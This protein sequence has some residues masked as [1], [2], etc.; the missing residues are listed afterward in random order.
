MLTSFSA[1]VWQHVPQLAYLQFPWRTLALLA[2]I[3]ALML[4]CALPVWIKARS[5][6]LSALAAFGI[7]AL[8]GLPAWHVFH[9]FCDPEDTAPARIAL[10]HSNAGTDPADYTPTAA[11]DDA[12]SHRNPAWWLTDSPDT[13]AP[14]EAP[15]SATRTV[16]ANLDITAAHAGF[17]V[18]NLR[19][20][21]AWRVTLAHDNATPQIVTARAHRSDGLLTIPVPSGRSTINIRYAQTADQTAGDIITLIALALAAA[22]VARN[23][24]L[25]AMQTV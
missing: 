3:P 9:Q 2:P 6:S 8:F 13:E 10:F 21:P 15:D 20:Y 12:L 25:A 11:D 18:L 19:D 23:R 14:T 4:A 16:P 22:L 7:V 17:L 1:L 5:I 24:Q